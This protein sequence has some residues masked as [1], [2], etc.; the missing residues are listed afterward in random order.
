MNDGPKED[1][2]PISLPALDVILAIKI[3]AQAGT[4]LNHQEAMPSLSNASLNIFPFSILCIVTGNM[5]RKYLD[6]LACLNVCSYSLLF[7]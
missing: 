5:T 2:L 7:G 1:N 3:Y 4:F 6:N